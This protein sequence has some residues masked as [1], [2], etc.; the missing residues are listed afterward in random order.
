MADGL[1]LLD[2]DKSL[3]GYL[4]LREFLLAV[5]KGLYTISLQVQRIFIN[6]QTSAGCF[7][8]YNLHNPRVILDFDFLFA[9]CQ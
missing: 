6:Q 3:T 4:F 2:V 9:I 5:R 7:L 1:Q 8:N